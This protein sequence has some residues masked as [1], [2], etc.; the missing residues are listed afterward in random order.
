MKLTI[1]GKPQDI[2]ANNIAL[3][4]EELRLNTRQVAI[5]KNREI[6]PKSTYAAT[7]LSEGDAIEIVAFV[8][9]G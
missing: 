1:N 7:V 5:E 9:G 3:L 2:Q 6:V 4:V 8:G